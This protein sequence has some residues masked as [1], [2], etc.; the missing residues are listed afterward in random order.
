MARWK[1]EYDPGKICN[2]IEEVRSLT[3]DGKVKFA[4]FGFMTYWKLL[5]EM[6]DFSIE[7]P[8]IEGIR[9]VRSAIFDLGSKGE[10][11]SKSLISSINKHEQKYATQSPIRYVITTSISIDRSFRIDRNYDG[12][13]QIVFEPRLS[14]SYKKNLAQLSKE[15]AGSLFTEPAKDYLAVRVHVSG[16][17]PTEAADSGL[18]SLDFFRGIWNLFENRRHSL[19][20]SSGGKPKPVNKIILGPHHFLHYPNGKLA[21]ES[22]WWYERSYVAPVSTYRIKDAEKLVEFQNYFRST[23]KASHLYNVLRSAVIRYSRALDE[24]NWENAFLKLW[25]VL[26]LLTDTIKLNQIETIK[27]AASIYEENEFML[28]LLKQLRN[29]RNR[30]VHSDGENAELEYFL[31]QLKNII[32]DHLLFLARSGM[33]F[34]GMNQVGRFLSLPIEKNSL[35]TTE[36]M[37]DFALKFRG[38]NK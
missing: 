29:Y 2:R 1:G 22:S 25:G 35:K 17:S 23:I 28:Q 3:D 12:H 14:H 32:E 16:K 27:R 26:E 19:R 9:I 21:S 31:Y 37:V 5:Y 38:Y 30:S 15:A 11:N 10:I 7:I 33:Q 34:K 18:D 6:V 13:T 20:L 36:R 4:G 8:E 24:R